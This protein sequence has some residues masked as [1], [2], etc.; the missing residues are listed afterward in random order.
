MESESVD[1]ERVAKKI[2]SSDPD[3]KVVLGEGEDAN[4]Q[5]H[6][7]QTLATKSKYI[8]AMLSTPMKESDEHKITFPDI[9]LG[10]WQKMMLF[11][12]SPLA[13]RKMTVKD[14]LEV[15]S[16]Y[17]KY[18]FLEGSELCDAVMSDYFKST[19]KMEETSTLDLD[20]IIE[21]VNVAHKSNLEGAFKAG[22]NYIW[23][24][25]T[26][27]DR[28]IGR[29]MF[30][31]SMLTSLKPA[32]IYARD[33]RQSLELHDVHE[34]NVMSATQT[35]EDDSFAKEFV[36]S[37]QQ[38]DEF[39]LWRRCISHIELSGST[40]EADGEFGKD[41]SCWDRYRPENERSTKWGG[42]NV[43]W[44]IQHWTRQHRDNDCGDD[45]EGWAIVRRSLPTEFDD[46]GFAVPES[47][48]KK[49]CWVAPYS[50]NYRRPPCK[51]WVS[52]D[53]LARGKPKIKYVLNESVVW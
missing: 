44:R 25:M 32:L 1:D 17:D 5:L 36:S 6:H 16:I 37:C 15:A 27:V 22:I 8:D 18:D 51:G 30:T 26:S 38:W 12:D 47:I 48:I 23:D 20:L 34:R 2:R 40:C 24:K 19:R 35:F 4:F 13:A 43:H 21:L 10:T 46:D 33:N 7:S 49:K 53:P 41:I 52:V 45:F 42:Q 28:R 39:N 50:K 3:L 11:L 31:E 14:A 29:L 9:T